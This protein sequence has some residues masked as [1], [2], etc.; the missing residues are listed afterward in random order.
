MTPNGAEMRSVDPGLRRDAPATDAAREW[1]GWGTA[2]KP[3]WEPVILA[4]KPLSRTV[5]ANVLEHGTGGINVDACRVEGGERPH[6]HNLGGKSETWGGKNGSVSLGTTSEGR[7]PAN[8]VLCHTETC[9]E[10]CAAGCPVAELDRQT[11]TLTSGVLAAHHARAPKDAGILG[12]YGSAEG[13]RGYGDTG[14]GSRFFPIFRYEAKAPT[15][16]RPKLNGKAHPTVKPLDLMRWLVRL[17][18]PPGGVVLDCFAGTGTTLHAARAEGF[19]AI[20]I[21]RD[22][23]SIPLIV[24]RLDGYREPSPVDPQT[25]LVEPVDLLD[26]LDGGAA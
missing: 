15:A 3:A 25:G 23:E 4:R 20:G 13:E 17:L 24:S 26:L 19:R 11:G 5:A 2:L 1:D 8:V 6:I 22:P 7:W 14:G 10:V 21:E 12:A 9:G 18:T 16:E